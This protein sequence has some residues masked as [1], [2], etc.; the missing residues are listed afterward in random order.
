M[1]IVALQHVQ[2][3]QT[4]RVFFFVNIRHLKFT[5]IK[6]LSNK[7]AEIEYISNSYM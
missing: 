3:H 1:F 7:M 2:N 4:R 6:L 5:S